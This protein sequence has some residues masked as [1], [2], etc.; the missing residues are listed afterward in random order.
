VTLVHGTSATHA[1]RIAG[2]GLREPFPGRG[3]FLCEAGRIAHAYTAAAAACAREGWQERVRA[4]LVRV[5]PERVPGLYV[6]QAGTLDHDVRTYV[7]QRVPRHAIV[8]MEYVSLRLPG[9]LSADGMRL[10]LSGFGGGPMARSVPVL[11]LLPELVADGRARPC[12]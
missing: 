9:P 2:E 8:G 4:L 1:L 10:R 3:V 5:D 7:C 11:D 12:A 6:A